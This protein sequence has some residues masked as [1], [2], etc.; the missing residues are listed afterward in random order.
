MKKGI[1][2]IVIPLMAMMMFHANAQEVKNG[3]FENWVKKVLYE[4]PDG[5]F[6]SGMQLSMMGA[7]S[8][9]TKSTDKQSG[10]YAIKLET[11]K[12]GE[13]TIPG[14][15]IAGKP[16]NS[17]LGGIPFSEKP[18]SLDGYV[19]YNVKPG[20]TAGL[21]C[22][23]LFQGNIIGVGA[24]QVTGIQPVYTSFSIPITFFI[25]MVNPDTLVL[26]AS[27]SALDGMKI[28]GSVVLLDHLQFI[29]TTSQLPNND[30]ENWT[31][32]SFEEPEGWLSANAFSPDPNIVSVTKTTD[33]QQGNYAAKITNISIM[34]GEILGFLTNGT[35]GEN[36]PLGGMPVFN[37]PDKVKFYY[38]YIPNGPDT[39]VFFT[40]LTKWDNSLGI[41]VNVEQKQIK[42]PPTPN[43][44]YFEVSYD[45]N[46]TPSADT[47]N[48]TFGSGNFIDQGNYVGLGSALYIDNVTVTYKSS[49][50]EDYLAGNAINIYP[51]P[52]SDKITIDIRDLFKGEVN[53]SMT[54]Q[55][56]RI[57]LNKTISV[58][59]DGVVKDIDI[60]SLEAGIYLVTV[61]SEKYRKI[62][63]I[64]VR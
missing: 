32:V 7:P 13:D 10:S 33:Y 57:V 5:Y 27:S 17:Q 24:K 49:S 40:V 47:L 9:V 1:S 8:N 37:N 46:Q 18:T 38:K 12:T 44:T 2:L 31:E 43:Y 22:L 56:G 28:P 39:A 14:I 52:A 55:A 6:T 48:I 20:D 11:V 42:L 63:K 25:P 4:I 29:G 51:N 21:I 45:Y 19:K 50:V 26:I 15:I 53:I 64:T 59:D 41:S 58:D 62:Q 3:S 16:E 35:I 34:S 54:D 61:Q 60:S 23:F 30:F 36:G